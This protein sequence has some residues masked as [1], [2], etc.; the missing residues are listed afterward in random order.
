M[1]PKPLKLVIDHYRRL[2]DDSVSAQARVQMELESARRTLRTLEDYRQE[3]LQR[4]RDARQGAAVTTGQLLLQTRFTGKLDEAI[5]LQLQ[6]IAEIEHRI[7]N[8]RSEVLGHQQRLKAIETIEEQRAAR[9]E[10][11]AARADQAASDERAADANSRDRRLAAEDP[12]SSSHPS[13]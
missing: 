11:R 4:A 1:K 13:R 2:R 9:V 3:Q 6:R 5:A 8:C 12:S 7:V 10:E